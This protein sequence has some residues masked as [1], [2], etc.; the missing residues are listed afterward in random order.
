[1]SNPYMDTSYAHASLISEVTDALK[2][3]PIISN[4]EISEDNK[5]ISPR[6]QSTATNT[7]NNGTPPLN[8]INNNV[9]GV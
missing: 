5:E 9:N 8:N 6:I 4:T 1:M 2:E 3:N 7:M